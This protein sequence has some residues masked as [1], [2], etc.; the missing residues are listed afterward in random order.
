MNM[1][2]KKYIIIVMMFFYKNNF[3]NC[4]EKFNFEALGLIRDDINNGE[5]TG[6]KII[7][8][9]KNKTDDDSVKNLFKLLKTNKC[10]NFNKKGSF[11]P[12]G[13]KNLFEFLNK[14]DN[15]RWD[16][17]REFINSGTKN[18]KDV[19]QRTDNLKFLIEHPGAV[20]L[21][22]SN[23]DDLKNIKNDLKNLSAD[24]TTKPIAE[25][26]NTI[27]SN[28]EIVDMLK[29]IDPKGLMKL[30]DILKLYANVDV[31]D[32]MCVEGNFVN[33]Y[34]K[35]LYLT[36]GP[37]FYNMFKNNQ[38]DI[39]EIAKEQILPMFKEY[40]DRMKQLFSAIKKNKENE[41]SIENLK[42]EF[43]KHTE[44]IKKNIKKVTDEYSAEK[45]KEGLQ[46]KVVGYKVC[47]SKKKE[48]SR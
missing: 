20:N 10:E 11:D 17:F 40:T 13:C 24:I 38:K 41:K 6:E 35:F 22:E 12:A 4:S 36:C 46:R 14:N 7:K 39:V 2:K 29:E 9:I 34:E 18:E 21:L 5:G 30:N 27:L 43:K 32:R 1:F 31:R 33:A 28:K 48:V 37:K 45:V 15:K 3:V 47:S 8:T 42:E 26:Y 44:E 23:V 16:N 25:T 19:K